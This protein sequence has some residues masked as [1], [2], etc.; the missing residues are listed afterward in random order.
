ML[1]LPSRA[2][3]HAG[4]SLLPDL[5]ILLLPMVI[6]TVIGRTVEISALEQSSPYVPEQPPARYGPFGMESLSSGTA[7]GEH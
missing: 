3:P 4:I 2:K 5:L 6:F 7:L 1:P